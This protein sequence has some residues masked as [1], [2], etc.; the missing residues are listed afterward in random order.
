VAPGDEF[1]I[2]FS[3][4]LQWDIDYTNNVCEY[5]ALVLGLEA[6]RKLKIKNSKVYGDAELIIKQI[7][8]RYQAKHPRLRSYKNCGWDLIEIFFSS[9]NVHYI[10]KIENQ[11]A[12]SLAKATST[13]VPP[14]D[15]KL[16]YHIEMRHRPSIPNNVQHWQVFEDDEQIRQLL[17]MVDEFSETHIDQENQ[18]D[19]VW[20][21]KEGEDP[22]EFQDKIANHHMLL[23]K[24]NQIPKGLI[25]LERLFNH[26]DIPLK[27]TLQ[28]VVVLMHTCR[29]ELSPAHLVCPRRHNV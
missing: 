17:E 6:A 7:N 2:P 28:P 18:N 26:D 29:R 5:E 9:V 20:I 1:I 23:L 11:Q 27:S 22:Q 12:D 16:K 21:M 25:P 13:F 19:L 8:R 10:P 15:F 24:N 14:T 4:R 3:Y